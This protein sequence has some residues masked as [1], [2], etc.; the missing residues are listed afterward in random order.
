MIS[1]IYRPLLFIVDS[2]Q[3]SNLFC[4][5]LFMSLSFLKITLMKFLPNIIMLLQGRNI[6]RLKSIISIHENA[7][8]W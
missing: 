2:R 6:R 4:T 8:W 3:Y 7:K 1:F 5:F